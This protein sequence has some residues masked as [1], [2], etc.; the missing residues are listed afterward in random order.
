MSEYNHRDIDS[1][2]KDQDLTEQDIDKQTDFKEQV[3]QS[4]FTDEN[5]IKETNQPPKSQN[6][7]SIWLSGIT[8]GLTVAV[9]G[10][11]LLFTGIIPLDV[12]HTDQGNGGEAME[13]TAQQIIQTASGDDHVSTQMLSDVSGAV[14]GISNIRSFDLWSDNTASGSGSGVIYKVDEENAYVITNH[15]VIEDAEEIEVIL[16]NGE[17]VRARLLGSDELTDLAVLAIDPEHVDTVATLGSSSDLVIGETAIAIGNPLGLEFAGTVTKGIISGLD[18]SL[19][20]DRSGDGSAD[21]TI[22]VIQTDAAINP[23]NSGGALINQQGEVIGINSMKIAT[24]AVEGIG[25]A[26]PIDEA[27]PIIEQL[28]ANGQISR[29]LLGISAVDLS[30]VPERNLRETLNLDTDVTDGIVIA[31]VHSGSGADEAGLQRYDVVTEINGES[32]SSML[33]LRR[34]LYT[35]TDIGETITITYYRDGVEQQTDV[36]LQGE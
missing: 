28:E 2:Q 1:E 10:F 8:G 35:E 4:S 9:I 19:E 18:R 15:H 14:V 20:V 3:E 22:D 27:L 13:A 12:N 11:L 5:N 30:T 25:F 26:I 36:T 6:L 17:Q 32:I 34:Y 31:D 24:H 29:P 16:A 23:G 33:N 7:W 21:W